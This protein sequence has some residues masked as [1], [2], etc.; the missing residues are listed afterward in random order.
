MLG[1][2]FSEII[3]IS[4]IAIIVLGPQKL[5]LL[6]DSLGKTLGKLRHYKQSFKAQIYA[7][8]KLDDISQIKHKMLQL[9][10]SIQRITPDETETGAETKVMHSLFHESESHPLYQPELDFDKQPELFDEL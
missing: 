6:A 10:D 7:H 8:T 2:S 1:I 3:L 9:Y 5:P 4:V